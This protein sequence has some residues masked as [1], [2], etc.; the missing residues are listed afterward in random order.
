MGMTT[1]LHQ[2]ESIKRL[3]SVQDGLDETH[4]LVNLRLVLP[5]RPSRQQRS[6]SNGV[7]I[8]AFAIG[9]ENGTTF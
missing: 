4:P 1:N 8:V 6:L 5:C 9:G 2:H 7:A 3:H